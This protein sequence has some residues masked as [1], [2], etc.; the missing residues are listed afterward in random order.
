MCG[1]RKRK[2][3]EVGRGWAAAVPAVPADSIKSA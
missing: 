2:V 1:Y 3:C